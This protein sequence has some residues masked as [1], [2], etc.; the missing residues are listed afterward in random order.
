MSVSSTALCSGTAL[1]ASQSFQQVEQAV[2]FFC[3]QSV[4]LESAAMGPWPAQAL[5]SD[6]LRIRHLLH[7]GAFMF[8][9]DL[10]VA[11]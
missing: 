9:A 7:V 10:C 1:V 11:I 3:P 6:G 8:K 5:G 2:S 4:F